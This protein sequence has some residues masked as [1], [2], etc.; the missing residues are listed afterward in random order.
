MSVYHKQLPCFSAFS[1]YSIKHVSEM[2]L[3]VFLATGW[4]QNQLKNLIYSEGFSDFR[5][6]LTSF[7]YY[8]GY[9]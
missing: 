9:Q 1:Y 7:K 2:F 4:N 6:F 5:R 8:S 3:E